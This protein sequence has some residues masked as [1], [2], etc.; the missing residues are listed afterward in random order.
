M[1]ALWVVAAMMMLGLGACERLAQ[2]GDPQAQN[3]SR[4][5]DAGAAAPDR[6]TACG[7][8]I[9]SGKLTAAEHADALAN[10]GFAHSE[11]HDP[12]AA[13]R[14]FS[15]A[16]AL[17][18]ANTHAKLGRAM[19][20][21]DSGQLDAALPIADSLINEGQFLAEAYF[22]R[23]NIRARQSDDA[24]AISDFNSSLQRNGRNA[25]ALAYRA[26]VK[27]RTNDRPGA[28]AD[29]DAAINIDARH[30]K[31]LAGRCWNRIYQGQEIAPARAD[32]E[33][34]T[35]ADADLVAA[36]LCL[37]FALL[38]QE[39]WSDARAAYDVALRLSPANAA[40]LY[41]RGIA[42]QKDGDH[43]GGDDDF[44][45]AYQFDSHIDREFSRYG[46]RR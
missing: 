25:D 15:A 27:Q 32:A 41:G 39:R 7:A 24:A 28:R 18:A 37:G 1:R 33:A 45:R 29:F 30:A 26:L 19:I 8:V 43:E 2:S 21:A 10:R 4:C 14:D 17:D 5:A 34:A 20:L 42:R 44:D 40:A 11:N 38:K 46:V 23:G 9:E 6:I 13:L 22:V 36:R 12:T 3:R 31:A 16:L 35:Q